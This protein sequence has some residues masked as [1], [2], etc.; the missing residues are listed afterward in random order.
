MWLGSGHGPWESQT[1]KLGSSK[2]KIPKTHKHVETK[3]LKRCFPVCVHLWK[4][5][6]FNFLRPKSFSEVSLQNFLGDQPYLGSWALGISKRLWKLISKRPRRVWQQS[7][8]KASTNCC[9][10]R[11]ITSWSKVGKDATLCNGLFPWKDMHSGLGVSLLG[12]VDSYRKSVPPK[13]F[14][15]QS[16]L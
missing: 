3:S 1:P 5:G 8:S 6:F 11:H 14:V 2:T 12:L 7:F 9:Q 13:R 4:V 10:V 15:F 16:F